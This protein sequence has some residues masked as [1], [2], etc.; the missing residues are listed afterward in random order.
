MVMASHGATWADSED[1]P[2]ASRSEYKPE[3]IETMITDT[4]LKTVKGKPQD[5]AF[6]RTDRD[7]LSARVST[8]GRITWQLRFRL[9]GRQNRMDLGTYPEMTLAQARQEALRWRG[10]AQQGAD[11]RKAR[12]EARQAVSGAMTVGA[13]VDYWLDNYADK[14]I[15]NFRETRRRF[16]LY[17]PE[18][19]AVMRADSVSRATWFTLL[20]EVRERARE[21]ARHLLGTLRQ[22]H[23]YCQQRGLIE[24]NPLDGIKPKDLD[25]SYTPRERALSE[26]EIGM[27]WQALDLAAISDN[28]RCFFKLLL[29]TG[30]RRGELAKARMRDFDFERG[31]WTVPAENSKTGVPT[32]RPIIGPVRALVEQA[33]AYSTGDEFVFAAGNGQPPHS[34]TLLGIPIRLQRDI[35]RRGHTMEHWSTHDLRR[36][37]RTFWS[38]LTQPH[39]AEK[40]LG[41]KLGGVWQVYDR[42]DYL[43]EQRAAYDAWWQK[44]R[45]IIA[46][47]AA[48]PSDSSHARTSSER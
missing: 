34:S 43:D 11:P 27:V 30:A 7:G 17:L 45:R 39:I 48:S 24:H 12:E 9:D 46:D 3:Y 21:Q 16:E 29:I 37:A 19:I 22:A 42:H 25:I 33:F 36:T 41:H 44:L 28:Y 2:P 20:D 40:M 31:V 10:V 32:K 18:R 14:R 38:S 1:R 26:Q 4:W 8:V 35:E 47:H 13:V 5:A 23:T 6:E 15:K